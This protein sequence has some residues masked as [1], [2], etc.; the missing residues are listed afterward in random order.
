[1]KKR[2]SRRL[3]SLEEE[4]KAIERD[5]E[6]SKQL[7]QSKEVLELTRRFYGR[8]S[9]IKQ[10]ISK[11]VMSK[12]EKEKERQ[13]R[14]SK[15]SKN[16][17]SKMKTSWQFWK[18]IQRNYFPDKTLKE[19]RAKWKRHRQGLTTDIPDVVWRNPSP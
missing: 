18:S 11:L 14:L 10:Q 3:Q 4:L 13:T 8:L 17:S 12:E 19:I 2:N 9:F 16:R 5:I 6:I 1:M 15:A 7:R